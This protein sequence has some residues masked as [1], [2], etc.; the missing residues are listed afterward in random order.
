MIINLDIGLLTVEP[1]YPVFGNY[2]RVLDYGVQGFDRVVGIGDKLYFTSE[3]SA[4][5]AVY[6]EYGVFIEE[7]TTTSTI[8]SLGTDGTNLYIMTDSGGAVKRI[9]KTTGAYIST[10]TVTIIIPHPLWGVS[11]FYLD[12]VVGRLIYTAYADAVY[13][14]NMSTNSQI[15]REDFGCDDRGVG[16]GVS[17]LGIYKNHIITIEPTLS[18][19]YS[20]P[21]VTAH[22]T[23]SL[24]G[25]GYELM[26]LELD[27]EMVYPSA[28]TVL[29]DTLY[30][31]NANGKLFKAMISPT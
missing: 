24:V 31:L 19:Y 27:P 8:K 9:D 10:E 23:G 22:Y 29:G 6:S 2:T 17:G 14:K 12:K 18:L 15:Y 26:Y 3:G 20:R 1:P 21:Y 28:A 13:I 4:N 30:L 25:L 11:G 7:L 5:I 16:Q